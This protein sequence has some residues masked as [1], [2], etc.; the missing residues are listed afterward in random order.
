MFNLIATGNN[1]VVN[2]G[3]YIVVNIVNIIIIIINVVRGVF[4]MMDCEYYHESGK[5][6]LLMSYLTLTV[7]HRLVQS[8]S[9]SSVASRTCD[10][11]SWYIIP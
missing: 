2:I 11:V 4:L 7:D 6:I 10:K 8:H 5:D 3:I 9:D 1:I